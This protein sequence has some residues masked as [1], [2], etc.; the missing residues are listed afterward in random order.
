MK[1]ATFFLKEH[2]YQQRAEREVLAVLFL[3]FISYFISMKM[4][5][6]PNSEYGSRIQSAIETSTASQADSKK[7]IIDLL[8]ACQPES[9]IDKRFDH[10]TN[11]KN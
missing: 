8:W 9:V 10:C 1:A 3:L 4:N 5:S 6:Q 2:E 11:S 7:N